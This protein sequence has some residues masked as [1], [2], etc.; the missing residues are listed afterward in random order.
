[1]ID[2][3]EWKGLFGVV[4]CSEVGKEIECGF[5]VIAEES[6]NFVGT[7]ELNEDDLLSEELV[8]LA[9][10]SGEILPQLVN[11]SVA[12]DLL[13]GWCCRRRSRL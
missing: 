5:L 9:D 1:M 2:D 8:G 3:F 11:E 4:N 7:I 12:G 6:E 13:E 10:R